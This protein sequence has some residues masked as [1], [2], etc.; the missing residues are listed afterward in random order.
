MTGRRT[1]RNAWLRVHRWLGLVLG[2]WFV[3]LGLTGSLLVF[4]VDLEPWFDA[5]LAPRPAAQAPSVEGVVQALQAAHP[6]RQAGWRI[7][8]PQQGQALVTARYLRPAETAGSAF[9]PLLVS[10]DGRTKQVVASRLWGDTAMT[11]VYDLHYQLLLGRAGRQAVALAGLG[12]ALSLLSG[13]WL[14]WPSAARWREALRFKW[15]ASAPRRV[16]D[17]HKWAG[18]VALPL[19]LVL[20][21]SGSML[22]WP[23]LYEPAVGLLGRPAAWPRPATR[24]AGPRLPIDEVLAKVQARWPQARLRWVDVPG[25]DPAATYRVRMQLPGEPGARFPASYAWVDASTGA[26]LAVRTPAQLKGPDLLNRWLHPLHSGE[27][28]GLTGRVLVCVAGL[29]PLALAVTGTLRWQ[30]KRR[31]LRSMPGR[32]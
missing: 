27:A 30:H 19:L 1:L 20:A 28:L 14:W 16:Y 21:V 17:L 3:L 6:Q 32:G 4:Y 11:W 2:A 18:L 10:V 29:L 22:G 25:N 12:L 8:L 24:S 9:A 5:R 23:Q 26:V 13:L 31:A 15:Q 7:E